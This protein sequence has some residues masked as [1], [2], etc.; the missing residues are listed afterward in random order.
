MQTGFCIASRPG[1]CRALVT[2]AGCRAR[3]GTSKF[4]I[5][6]AGWHSRARLNRSA[7]PEL[8]PMSPVSNYD[9]RCCLGPPAPAARTAGPIACSPDICD[10]A[11]GNKLLAPLRRAAAAKAAAARNA[12]VSRLCGCGPVSLSASGSHMPGPARLLNKLIC[13]CCQTHRGPMAIDVEIICGLGDPLPAQ[14][15]RPAR[16]RSPDALRGSADGR[17]AL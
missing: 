14:P 2:S 15:A 3:R 6:W 8:L 17:S 13:V 16:R 11:S 1:S 12:D 9:S 5:C 4:R 10:M 7:F